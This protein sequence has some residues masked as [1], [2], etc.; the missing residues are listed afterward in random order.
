MIQHQRLNQSALVAHKRP[1]RTHA[2]GQIFD[3]IRATM[4]FD[5]IIAQKNLSYMKHEIF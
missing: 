3:R 4:K 1:F 5:I 2:S